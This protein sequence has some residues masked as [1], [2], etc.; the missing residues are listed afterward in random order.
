MNIARMDTLCAAGRRESQGE[1]SN[2]DCPEVSQVEE[3]HQR[4]SM[5]VIVQAHATDG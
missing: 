5:T 2:V 1:G 4:D 3:Q